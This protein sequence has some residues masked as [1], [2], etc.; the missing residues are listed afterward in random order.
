VQLCYG[1]LVRTAGIDKR[2][3]LFTWIH[4]DLFSL[5]LGTGSFEFKRGSPSKSFLKNVKYFPFFG[6]RESSGSQ[7]FFVC[8]HHLKGRE[9]RYLLYSS[10]IKLSL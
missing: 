4:I 2:A 3:L 7:K 6:M 8:F 1:D 5:R 10:P 9:S